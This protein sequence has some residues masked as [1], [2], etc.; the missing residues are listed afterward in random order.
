M[1]NDKNER[2]ICVLDGPEPT[3]EQ[4][5]KDVEEMREQSKRQ[6]SGMTIAEAR[7]RRMRE[8]QE[9]GLELWWQ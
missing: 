2:V 6:G 4:M 1:L 8:M 9:Q 7:E 3:Y 5:L